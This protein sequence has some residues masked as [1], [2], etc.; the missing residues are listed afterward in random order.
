MRA[1]F[2]F[3]MKLTRICLFLILFFSLFSCSHIP[4][5]DFKK[6]KRFR[7]NEY[8]EVQ[9]KALNL[10]LQKISSKICTLYR[11]KCPRV[12]VAETY[13]VQAMASYDAYTFYISRGMLYAIKNEAELVALIGHEIGHFQ[14]K[15]GFDSDTQNEQEADTFNQLN[16]VIEDI[17][18]IETPSILKTKL[19]NLRA[20]QFNQKNE[21]RADEFGIQVAVQLK[22]NPYAFSELFERLSLLDDKSVLEKIKAVEGSHKTLVQRAEHIRDYLKLRD[23]KPEGL[24]NEEAYLQAT[25]SLLH[26]GV[27]SK[28]DPE[29]EESLKK[30]TQQINKRVQTPKKLSL[31]E[32][33]DYMIR[34]REIASRLDVLSELESSLASLKTESPFAKENESEFM[35]EL[36]RLTRPLWASDA[37]LEKVLDILSGLAKTGVGSLPV[38]GDVIDFYEFVTGRDFYTNQ[39][40]SLSE[41]AGS[42]LSVIAGSGEIWRASSKGLGQISKMAEDVNLQKKYRLIKNDESRK[43]LEKLADEISTK[44]IP[45]D[46]RVKATKLKDNRSQGL[47]FMHPHRT[48]VNVRV[49]PGDPKSEF[50]NSRRPYV[51]QTVGKTSFDK[52]GKKTLMRS[53]EAHIPLEEYNFIKFW[54]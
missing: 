12:A 33:L 46:W 26:D 27:P 20:A 17:T 45:D 4:K 24:I 9:Y 1:K 19:E 31:D 53:N 22:Y 51:R 41:R 54:D 2:R 7:L 11:Q 37:N 44:K 13:D 14:L 15:H 8:P 43:V 49:M 52:T 25:H 40:L 30:L 5:T 39:P 16:E 47:Q 21:E 34:L 35:M 32:F 10:Y 38:V 50:P 3:I 6:D 42:A 29:A 48:D 28:K 36:I 18:N 23:A